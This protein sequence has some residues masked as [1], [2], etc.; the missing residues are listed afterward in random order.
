MDTRSS[1]RQVS[2]Q[3]ITSTVSCTYI[4]HFLSWFQYFSLLFFGVRVA[5]WWWGLMSVEV[6]LFTYSLSVSNFDREL[7]LEGGQTFR[8]IS[9]LHHLRLLERL[10]LLLFAIEILTKAGH[11][12]WINRGAWLLLFDVWVVFSNNI[13]V[14]RGREIDT[15]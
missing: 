13:D 11:S 4:V 8:E 6:A 3:M 5:S 10:L 12:M 15:Y 7:L 1:L 14:I 9:F 2:C